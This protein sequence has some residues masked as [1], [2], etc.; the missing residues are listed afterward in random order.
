MDSF[1]EELM[2][3]LA[4]E[5]AASH[6]TMFAAALLAD[7]DIPIH[8]ALETLAYQTVRDMRRRPPGDSTEVNLTL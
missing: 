3:R 4:L 5:L 7:M 8:A 2:L 6:G 1:R